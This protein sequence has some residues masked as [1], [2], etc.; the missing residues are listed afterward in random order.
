MF[1]FLNFQEDMPYLEGGTILSRI[2]EMLYIIQGQKHTH[3]RHLNQLKKR[4]EMDSN[5]TEDET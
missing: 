3:K 4:H 2:G 5:N 1:F